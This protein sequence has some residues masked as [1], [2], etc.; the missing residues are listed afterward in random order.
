MLI[1]FVDT[2]LKSI[3]MARVSTYL[4]FVRNTEE[5]FNFYK[6]VFGGE[7]GGMDIMRF[8]DVP[9]SA[10]LTTL[11]VEDKDLVMHRITHHGRTR[12]NGY[13]CT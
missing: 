1:L 9:P 4:N 11:A 3:F 2:C 6:S 10:G 5:A 12:V 7:F 13:G 8:S